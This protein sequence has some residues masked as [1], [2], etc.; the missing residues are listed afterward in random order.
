MY[1]RNAIVLERYFSKIFE[2]NENSNLKS[3]YSNYCELLEKL[4]IYNDATFSENEATEEFEKV[5]NE[6]KQIQKSRWKIV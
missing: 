4:K 3:N 5:S 1:E 6:I 2:F